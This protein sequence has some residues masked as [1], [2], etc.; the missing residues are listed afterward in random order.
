MMFGVL[1]ILPPVATEKEAPLAIVMLPSAME[2][3]EATVTPPA[4]MMR[5]P[6][7]VLLLAKVALPEPDLV[8]VATPPMPLP[9]SAPE[10]V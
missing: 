7:S 8:M 1:A 4:L 6:V 5:S 9:A 2:P 3:P 10:K